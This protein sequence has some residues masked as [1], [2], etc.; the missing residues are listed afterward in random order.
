MER[1]FSLKDWVTKR[2]A[3]MPESVEE[4]VVLQAQRVGDSM[5]RQEKNSKMESVEETEADDVGQQQHK[6]TAR[7]ANGVAPAMPASPAQQIQI[8]RLL[9]D[10]GDRLRQS[11]KEREI[12]WRELDSCRKLLTDIEDKTSKT[13]KAFLS[14]EHK[15]NSRPE[16][17]EENKQ[18]SK[19]FRKSIED[20]IAA[21]E[22]T[23]GSAVLRL[24][25]AISENSKLARRVEQVTQDK[26]RL[27][28]KLET[29]E[30]TLTQTQDALKAKALVLLTDAALASKTGMPQTSAWSGNDTLRTQAAAAPASAATPSLTE[31]ILGDERPWWKN[32]TALNMSTGTLVSLVVLGLAGGWAF[33]KLDLP[34]FSFKPSEVSAPAEKPVVKA[35]PEETSSAQ[36]S[37]AAQAK[38]MDDAAKIASQI[39][40]G[41]NTVSDDEQAP[42]VDADAD[43]AAPAKQAAEEITPD[44]AQ[45]AAIAAEGKAVESFNEEKISGTLSDRI[46]PDNNLSAAVK[47]IQTKAFAGDAEAQHDLAAIYTA[48]HAGVKTNYPKAALWFTEAAHKN[49][50]NAQYNLAVL[51]HQG[52]GVKQDTKKAINLYRIAASNNHP[53][54]QYNLGIAHI[55][56]IGAD[57]NPQIAAYYFQ[58]A[59]AGG[60]VE[61]AYNIGLIQENGLLGEAQPDEA[62]FWYTLASNRGNAQATEA[63]NQ[64]TGQ[65]NLNDQQVSQ[66]Y[67]RMA[68]E[69]AEYVKALAPV[70][71][72]VVAKP[73]IVREAP[74][75]APAKQAKVDPPKAPI[76]LSPTYDPVIVAQIQEQLIRLGLYSGSADGTADAG[77]QDAVKSYQ[78]MNKL[79]VD[80]KPTEDVLVHMLA[81]DMQAPASGKVSR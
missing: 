49:I 12:L 75:A 43:Q 33:S 29:M 56:G 77:T 76:S 8:V 69:K 70:A 6:M 80:G 3:N 81:S 4:E 18:E 16:E 48:G 45:K 71:D 35:V 74:P 19:E 14:I 44:E 54:A 78:S 63:L 53:E 67:K 46:K 28:Q 39:E 79:K 50:P 9:R 25:D 47:A 34:K 31:T 68:A 62:I 55:E 61:A 73:S 64:L 40:P 32:P 15:M 7:I 20:K 38:L 1:D 23:T 22:T 2:A 57:Y 37:D 59:A 58:K 52:L 65:M 30:E 27:L 66:I 5:V 72:K 11:E 10:L 24:E 42:Q 60:V 36:S 41:S 51:Y 26:S 13:E 17:S 21:L